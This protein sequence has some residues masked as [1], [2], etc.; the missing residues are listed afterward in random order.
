MRALSSMQITVQVRQWI[1]GIMR[2]RSK[3][4][5]YTTV[6]FVV[7]QSEMKSEIGKRRKRKQQKQNQPHDSYPEHRDGLSRLRRRKQVRVNVRNLFPERQSFRFAGEVRRRE[8]KKKKKGNAHQI[9]GRS[10]RGRIYPLIVG[11]GKGVT[12]RAENMRSARLVPVP[13]G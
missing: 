5:L 6:Q 9:R 11:D 2:E 10:S 8:K 7:K 13:A 3:D 4:S 1:K 12:P